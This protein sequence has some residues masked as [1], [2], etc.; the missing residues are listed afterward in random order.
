MF[1]EPPTPGPPA[2]DSLP[3]SSRISQGPGE[4]DPRQEP[5]E[6]PARIPGGGIRTGM[7]GWRDEK[8]R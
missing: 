4:P 7:L 8:S 6:S 3:D 1:P 5:R 2:S